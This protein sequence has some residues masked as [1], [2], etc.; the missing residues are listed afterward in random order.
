MSF[1]NFWNRV[2]SFL[3]IVHHDHYVHIWFEIY[4]FNPITYDSAQWS[5]YIEFIRLKAQLFDPHHMLL[6]YNIILSHR[7]S[8]DLTWFEHSWLSILDRFIIVVLIF[9]IA[10]F[11]DY[12][13]SLSFSQFRSSISIHF[14]WFFDGTSM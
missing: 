10:L 5:W 3:A 9:W 8:P 1:L 13:D 14:I 12:I 2:L 7:L 4:F 11:E 6:A